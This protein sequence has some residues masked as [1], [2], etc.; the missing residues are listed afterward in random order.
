M[1]SHG[2]AST[3]ATARFRRRR[4]RTHTPTRTSAARSHEP[5]LATA[6]RL[7]RS[8]GSHTLKVAT[9][10]AARGHAGEDSVQRRVSTRK[11]AMPCSLRTA[12]MGTRAPSHRKR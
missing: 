2:L 10:A 8:H 3:M 7:T 11:P 9:A 12:S 4:S 1:P 6:A 5:R